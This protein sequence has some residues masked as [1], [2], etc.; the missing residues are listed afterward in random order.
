MKRDLGGE[1]NVLLVDVA[2]PRITDKCE[3]DLSRQIF[4]LSVAAPGHSLEPVLHMRSLAVVG[5][6]LCQIC[7]ADTL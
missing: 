7:Q 3:K 2:D 4:R 5:R 1:W 6:E